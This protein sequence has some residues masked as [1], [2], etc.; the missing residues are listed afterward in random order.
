MTDRPATNNQLY[1]LNA[2]AGRLQLLPPGQQAAPI[3]AQQANQAIQ[4]ALQDTQA[5]TSP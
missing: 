1:V 3:T 5:V 2:K 4:E